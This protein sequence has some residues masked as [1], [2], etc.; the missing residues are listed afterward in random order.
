[1]NEKIKNELGL[2]IEEFNM[3]HAIIDTTLH[4]VLEDANAEG[5]RFS[6]LEKVQRANAM[7]KLAISALDI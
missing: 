7:M 4:D 5:I 2:E 1:M 3:L 6:T